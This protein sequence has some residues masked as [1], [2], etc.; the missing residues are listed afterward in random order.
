LGTAAVKVAFNSRLLS[1]PSLRGWNRYTINLLAELPAFDVELFLHADKPLHPSH[2]A[3]LPAG[4]YQVR[5]APPMKYTFWE[6]HWLPRQCGRDG[7]EILHCPLNFGL[8]WLCPCPRVLTLHDAID[9]VYPASAL[10][11]RDLPRPAALMS[12]LRFWI[13]RTRA[14]HIIADSRHARDDLVGHLGIHPAR[15]SVIPLAADRHFQTPVAPVDRERVRQ[16]HGLE[17]P[18]IFYVGGWEKRKNIPLLLRA[19]AAA[20][21]R[22]VELLLGGGQA[23]QQQELRRRATDLGVADRVRLVGWVAEEDLP[24]LYAEALCFVYPSEYE[25]FGLQ[26]CEAMAVGCPVL[27]ANATSLP[28]V[29]GD[30]GLTFGL[31]NPDELAGLLRRIS[32]DLDFRKQLS[33]AALKR[34]QGF[35]WERTA[36]ATV[37]VYQSLAT[38]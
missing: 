28:E 19:F 4:S 36:R 32:A 23:A 17:K 6:Q 12:R 13:A 9:Q 10:R 38:K 8:P 15:I 34:S 37:K 25:G 26:L 30:G 3:R 2:L 35:L 22:E 20:G 21:L 14:D 33:E 1:A 16:A 29:L 24:A 31:E 11:W 7:V 18:Y 5:V 27:A